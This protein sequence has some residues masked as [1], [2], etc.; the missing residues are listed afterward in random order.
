MHA[1]QDIVRRVQSGREKGT[2]G[3]PLE[4]GRPEPGLPRINPPGPSRSA[5]LVRPTTVPPLPAGK[6]PLKPRALTPN[7]R[8][9]CA[10]MR[11]N[12][13]GL[14]HHAPAMTVRV[15]TDR[16]LIE[17]SPPVRNLT[18]L[19]PASHQTDPDITVQGPTVPAWGAPV[20]TARVRVVQVQP[21][22]SAA[23]VAS[24]GPSPPVP[25]SRVQ[26]VRDPAPS[27]ARPAA[28][29]MAPE[30]ALDRPDREV[31]DHVR[32]VLVRQAPVRV[33]KQ[34]G[35]PNLVSAVLP[36]PLPDPARNPSL[37]DF[38]NPALKGN[39]QAQN[40]P[41]LDPAGSAPTQKSASKSQTDMRR[42]HNLMHGRLVN[43][44][45]RIVAFL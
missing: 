14:A 35:S 20:Q 40:A 41:A 31:R 8:P 6:S 12:R 9:A 39:L 15:R 36:G 44:R 45:N 27:R 43:K 3:E 10:L 11:S 29:P 21:G 18:H 26:A 1:R 38:R 42:Y 7:G 25:A 4:P 17:P 13:I 37:A 2:R 34:A 16:H 30:P 5:W 22:H 23:R 28:T 32:A 19:D 24:A 33:D